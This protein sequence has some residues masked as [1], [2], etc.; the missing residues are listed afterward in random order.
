MAR[1]ALLVVLFAILAALCQARGCARWLWWRACA[2]NT[3]RTSSA[4][5]SRGLPRPKRVRRA[6]ARL[7]AR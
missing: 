1:H 6:C 3:H 5:T 4:A 2:A 7:Y